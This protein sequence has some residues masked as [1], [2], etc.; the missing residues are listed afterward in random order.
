MFPLAFVFLA[1]NALSAGTVRK[2]VLRT[3]ATLLGFAL[4]AGPFIFALSKAKD[5][6]TFGDSGKVNYA[7]HLNGVPYRHWQGEPPGS[8]TPRHPTRKVL[9][10][11]AIYEFGSP[12]EV[13][14]PVWYDP[15]YWYEGVRTHF[16]LAA[17]IR[18]VAA[19]VKNYFS[20]LS[21]LRGSLIMGLLILFYMTGRRWLIAKDISDY[22]FLIIPAIAALGMYSLVHVEERYVA[23]FLVLLLLGLFCSV[24]LPDSRESGRL[25]AGVTAIIS[26]MFLISVVPS[27]ALAAYSTAS[28]FVKGG[29]IAPNEYSQV[30]V[31]LRAMGV[32]PGT[33][34][35]SLE[36]SNL[37]N[38]NWARLAGVRIVAEMNS[39]DE[40]DFW[41]ADSSIK[42]QIIQ[43]L[44]RT[45]AAVIVA[46][47]VPPSGP[48]EGWLKIGNTTYYVYFLPKTQ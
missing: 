4:I 12:M 40:S 34:I 16:D 8:G 7:W 30:A 6:V 45:G 38:A 35:A 2:A 31:G 18:M 5:R 37:A 15:S 32:Q 42:G 46:H 23:P 33:R 9:D 22:W 27:S 48:A 36:Y 13:T 43:T 24:R 39:G 25:I 10:N 3:A 1:V 21:D 41:S 26:I 11:P 44:A 47:Q 28:E 29:E 19:N 14:Y 17:Q 20:T